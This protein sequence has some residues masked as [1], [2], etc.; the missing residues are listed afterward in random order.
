MREQKAEKLPTPSMF[1]FLCERDGQTSSTITKIVDSL[2]SINPFSSRIHYIANMFRF[3]LVLVFAVRLWGV[4]DL[5]E[6]QFDSKIVV[7]Y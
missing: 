1:P 6:L 5:M 7:K 2:A 3:V 4:C